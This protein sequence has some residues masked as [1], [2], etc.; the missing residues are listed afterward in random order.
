MFRILFPFAVLGALMFGSALPSPSASPWVQPALSENAANETACTA[1]DVNAL[2]AFINEI[3]NFNRSLWNSS[4]TCCAWKG[5]TCGRKF[6]SSE[7]MESLDDTFHGLL[8][9]TDYTVVNLS[10]SN[11]GLWGPISP[12]L[13]NLTGLEVLNLSGNYFHGSIP[14]ELL[15]LTALQVFDVS[16][17]NLTG[18]ISFLAHLQSLKFV[19]VSSNFLTGRLPPFDLLTSLEELDASNNSLQ[20]PINF[21]ICQHANNNVVALD[22]SRNNFTGGIQ[23]SIANCTLLNALNLAQNHLTGSIP[24]AIFS[25]GS[26]R[27]LYMQNNHLTGELKDGVGKLSNL[28]ELSLGFNVLYGP[29]PRSLSNCTHLKQL[30][31]NSNAF[32]GPIDLDWGKLQDLESINL[33]INNLTGNISPA[34]ANCTALQTL[35]LAKNRLAGEIPLQ[36]QNLRNL[37]SLSLSSNSLNGSLSVLVGCVQLVSL[38]LSKNVFTEVLPQNVT[39]FTRIQVLA[40]GYLNLRGEIPAWLKGCKNLQV[41][42]LSWNKLSGSIPEWLGDF[43]HLFYLEL[44]NNSFSGSI[45]PQLFGLPTLMHGDLQNSSL[46]SIVGNLAVKRQNVSPDLQYSQVSALPPSIYLSHNKLTGSIPGEVGNLKKLLNLDLSYNNLT[47]SIPDSLSS[48]TVLES[49]DVSENNLTGQIPPSLKNLTFLS[50]FNVSYNNLEGAIPE[51]NQFSTFTYMSYQGNPGLCGRPLSRSCKP[52][53]HPMADIS[54]QSSAV[55]S[56]MTRRNFILIIT[57]SI[58]FVLTVFLAAIIFWNICCQKMVYRGDYSGRDMEMPHNLTE[59]LSLSVNLFHSHGKLTV[60]DLFRATNNFDSANIVGCGGF[61]LVYRADL[62]DGSKLAIKKLT[63]DCGQ[64]EREFRAEV[65][66]LSKAQHKNLVSLQGYFNVG[67]DRLLIYSYMENGSLDY[68]LHEKG[69]GGTHLDWPTRLKIAQGTACGL[70][71]LHQICKPH[72]V[73]RDIKSSNIL[74]DEKFEAHLADFGL[75]RLM[76]STETHVTT[77]LVGTLGYI[78]PEYGQALNATLRGDVYSFGVVV[79][80]LLTRKRPVDVCKARETGDLVA[81]VQWMRCEGKSEEIFDILLQNKGHEEQMLLVLDIAC[82][83]IN[84]DPLKRPTVMDIISWLDVIQDT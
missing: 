45:P 76:M 31:L 38:I 81:W 10:L 46:Q 67:N 34:L 18:P 7:S 17:N 29:I 20:G 27:Q 22:F 84:K 77:E 30:A 8:A 49:L 75:A 33:S 69:D 1:Q 11:M 47:G 40:L 26:L 39:G 56:K 44:S 64:M 48:S 82:Q 78:P 62:G 51:G 21:D 66:A 65:E 5:V 4:V 58:V 52:S 43:P 12:W 59:A 50:V 42:D 68:W 9:S 16:V 36:F 37:S 74:L 6:L 54:P 57:I 71:Y 15:S 53:K 55:H 79:L 25:L 14:P 60:A 61:G 13:S 23:S 24:S 70:G 63:G 83:C 80:E 72:I 19:N 3:S 32:S 41:L 35:D 2:Q 28:V 73:H